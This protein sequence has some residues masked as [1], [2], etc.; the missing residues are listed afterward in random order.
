MKLIPVAAALVIIGL[1]ACAGVERP[2]GSAPEG[3]R[4]AD[5]SDGSDWAAFGRTFGEQHYSPLT[6][7]N[8][9]TVKDL[10]L[11]WSLDLGPGNPVTGPIVVDGVIYF[12]SGYSVVHAVD[13]A[14]GKLLWSYDPKVPEAAGRKL[15]QGWGSRGIAWWNGKVYTGTTDGRL[16]AIDTKTGQPVWSVRWQGDHRPWR[17][18]CRRDPWLCDDLRRRDRQAAL[19]L[20]HGS[21]K[22][23]RWLREQ[24]HGDGREDLGRGLVE[25][26]R[27]RHRLERDHL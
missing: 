5:D 20:L 3:A 9:G 11:A 24:G 8:D 23:C 4:I 19:A 26:W 7:I 27:R 10:G 6:E 16:M 18:R 21:R 13:A 22:P 25:I 17:R 2:A 14:S 12:A 1:A 15:R